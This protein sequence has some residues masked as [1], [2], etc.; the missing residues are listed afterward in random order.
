MEKQYYVY[1][2]T[3]KNNNVLYTG[4]TNDLVRT[5]IKIGVIYTAHFEIALSRTPRNDKQ[6]RNVGIEFCNHNMRSL[7]IKKPEGP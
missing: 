7:P 5:S 6:S 4:I 3:N 1:I 2:M